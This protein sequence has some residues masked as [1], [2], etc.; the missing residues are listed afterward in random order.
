M[1]G[2]T[3]P[4]AAG[5]GIPQRVPGPHNRVVDLVRAGAI[6]VV[7]VGHWLMA[8]FYLGE[9]DTL[10]R[11]DIL[12]LATWSHPLTW[13]L[14]VMPLFFVVGGFVNALSWR[15]ARRLRTPYGGWLR[16]RLRR[17]LAPLLPLLVFWALVAPAASAAGV[18]GHT[19]RLLTR[20]SLV[21][22]WF[23]AVYVLVVA[24]VPLTLSWWERW[25]WWSVLGGLVGAAL[26]DLVSFGTGMDMLGSAN[27][28]F[29]WV[30]AHQLGYAWQDDALGGTGRRLGLGLAALT[31][32]VAAVVLGPYAVS[33]V[34]VEG[35]GANN[36]YPPRLTLALLALAQVGLTTAAEPWLARLLRVRALWRAVVT[37]NA[38]IMSIYLWH[39]TALTLVVS[40]SLALG[41]RGL[42]AV[43]DTA[44]WWSARPAW[45]LALAIAT[46]VPVLLLGHLERPAPDPRPAPPAALPVLAMLGTGLSVAAMARYGIVSESGVVHWWLP[47]LPVVA[48]VVFGIFAL[49][50]KVASTSPSGGT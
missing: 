6:T 11:A 19:L 36:T 14:Q 23:L 7:V 41:G 34:G 18:S 25:G 42:R 39:L 10:R 12:A 5:S 49:P 20:A 32:A 45:C 47:W 13:V 15:S 28:L 30:T 29:V 4:E 35:F 27:L 17:L 50:Q 3:A 2:S 38:R 21:P 31:A 44:A 40:V 26:V 24:L 1:S 43:P 33:M 22:T 8:A 37:V 48:C 16:T 46:A 9:D